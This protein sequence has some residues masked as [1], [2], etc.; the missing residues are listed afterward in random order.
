M[1]LCDEGY[2]VKRSTAG[3]IKTGSPRWPSG[4]TDTPVSIGT[5]FVSLFQEG[6]VGLLLVR[7]VNWHLANPTAVAVIS[8]AGYAA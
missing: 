7:R 5:K 3:T 6:A 4:A 2:E 8:G 1:A